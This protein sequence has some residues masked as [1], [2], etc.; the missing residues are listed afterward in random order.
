MTEPNISVLKTLQ[1]V[2]SS[3]LLCPGC[4]PWL[5]AEPALPQKQGF[6]QNGPGQ[7][8]SGRSWTATTRACSEFPRSGKEWSNKRLLLHF[9]QH[10]VQRAQTTLWLQG[11]F[12][13]EQEKTPNV[14]GMKL[15]RR[16]N[17]KSSS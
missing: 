11:I 14:S 17:Y 7:K 8:G 13:D 3:P 6:H 9:L 5:A 1:D 2:F 12:K 10:E 16:H 15:Q 4:D